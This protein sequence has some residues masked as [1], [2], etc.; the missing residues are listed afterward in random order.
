MPCRCEF[1]RTL[2]GALA[3]RANET[4]VRMNSHL[5]GALF[6]GQ[7]FHDFVRGLTAFAVGAFL[8]AAG[9]VFGELVTHVYTL[10]ALCAF[11]FAMHGVFE[12]QLVL[13]GCADAAAGAAP[14]TSGCS[15]SLR[16]FTTSLAC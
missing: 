6:G 7:R 3:L 9:R 4:N 13:G 16:D 11:S 15:A 10:L 14:V 8:L 1:I 2:N 5:Q 12:V